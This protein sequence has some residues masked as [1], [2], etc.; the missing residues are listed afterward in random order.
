MRSS[1]YALLFALLLLSSGYRAESVAMAQEQSDCTLFYLALPET[2]TI[3]NS[4]VLHFAIQNYTGEDAKITVNASD[5]TIDTAFYFVPAR[6]SVEKDLA[7][8]TASGEANLSF[9]IDLGNCGRFEKQLH[10]INAAKQMPATLPAVPEQNMQNP[11]LYYTVTKEDGAFIVDV[12]LRNIANYA[13]QGTLF[14]EAPDEWQ[15][16]TKA[17]TLMPFEEKTF[18]LRVEPKSSNSGTFSFDVVFAPAD[19]SIRKRIFVEVEGKP[20]Y[21]G[22]FTVAVAGALAAIMVLIVVLIFAAI[23]SRRPERLK[24]EPWYGGEKK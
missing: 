2:I 21:S 5:A 23:V 9:L 12:S 15:S 18:R 24:K 13:L 14:I 19:F 4:G 22:L 3:E 1:F 20:F 8:S 11:Q 7:I 16:S 10:I 6:T 17:V